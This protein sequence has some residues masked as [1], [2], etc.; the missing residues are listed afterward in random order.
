MKK[1]AKD[2]ETEIGYVSPRL[3]GR[4]HELTK[5]AQRNY[6]RSLELY[7]QAYGMQEEYDSAYNQ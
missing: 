6:E 4:R 1:R 3:C 5:Q 7:Q 2:T